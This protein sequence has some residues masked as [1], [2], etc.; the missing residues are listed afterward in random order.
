MPLRT[1]VLRFLYGGPTHLDAEASP[2]A[3]GDQSAR[4]APVGA[5]QAFTTQIMTVTATS[6]PG[7]ELTS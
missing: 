6:K 1:I 7:P 5:A 4:V 3:S 2:V